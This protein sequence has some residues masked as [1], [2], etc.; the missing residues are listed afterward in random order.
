[1][2]HALA[3]QEG[4]KPDVRWPK[5]DVPGLG[6]PEGNQQK[7]K[8]KSLKGKIL[9]RINK[10]WVQKFPRYESKC[11]DQ[12]TKIVRFYPWKVANPFFSGANDRIKIDNFC[13]LVSCSKRLYNWKSLGAG[14]NSSNIV[15]SIIN[16]Q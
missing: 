5:P 16:S 12:N 10:T 1:M 2:P 14:S 9:L 3:Q 13:C 11:S 15:V 8:E 7:G 4:N 6:Q